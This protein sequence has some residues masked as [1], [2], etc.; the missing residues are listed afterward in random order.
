ML[1]NFRKKNKAD[2]NV[3]T[4]ISTEIV[5]TIT[6]SLLKDKL[7]KKNQHL[8]FYILSISTLILTSKRNGTDTYYL[9]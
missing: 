5:N 8:H 4:L 2:H 9:N 1:V 6:L 3:T 7:V